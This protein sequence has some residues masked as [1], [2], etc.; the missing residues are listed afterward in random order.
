M[1]GGGAPAGAT[2]QEHDGSPSSPSPS[3][4]APPGPFWLPPGSGW[5]YVADEGWAAHLSSGGWDRQRLQRLV[6]E[7]F[8][9]LR[10]QVGD[11]SGWGGY[12]PVA[13]CVCVVVVVRGGAGYHLTCT[14]TV[15]SSRL[16]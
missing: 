12:Q 13:V 8:P 14:V 15:L 4:R 7:G 3:S 5:R 2:T 6:E 16:T 10:L 11:D 1:P 9:E